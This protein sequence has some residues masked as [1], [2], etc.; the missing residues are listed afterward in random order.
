[1]Y[2]FEKNLRNYM[3]NANKNLDYMIN[4][5]KKSDFMLNIKK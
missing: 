3:I 4:A 2:I 5:D 1:M